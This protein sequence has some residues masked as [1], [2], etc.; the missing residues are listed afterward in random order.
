MTYS[1][2]FSIQVRY[3]SPAPEKRHSCLWS[4]K[5]I[6][7][8]EALVLQRLVKSA[9]P[10]CNVAQIVYN[11]V[12]QAHHDIQITKTDVRINQTHFF[13]AVPKLCRCSP[14]SSFYRLRLYLKLRRLP[15]MFYTPLNTLKSRP[16]REMLL[17]LS[18]SMLPS[19]KYANSMTVSRVSH[20]SG[21]LLIIWE[22]RRVG[23]N[24][25]PL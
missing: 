16:K 11:P 10:F 13:R 7:L 15:P 3:L 20:S 18:I 4:A 5:H 25:K 9:P 17:I 14:M 6:Q 23:Q 22:I 12:F 19:F 2:S 1:N 8:I 21:G 24:T